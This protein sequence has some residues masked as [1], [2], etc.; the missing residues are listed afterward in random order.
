MTEEIK[1][2]QITYYRQ[3]KPPTLKQYVYRRAVRETMAEI[4]GKTGVTV[5]NDTGCPIP[6]SALAAREA[7]RGVTAEL[8]LELHPEWEED[9]ERDVRGKAEGS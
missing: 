2:Q 8:I 9:Y 4:R 7:L 5:N 3:V 6:K 1:L